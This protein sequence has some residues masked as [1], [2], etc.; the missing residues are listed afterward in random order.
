MVF[1]LILSVLV[2]LLH[3]Y[4]WKR[5][6]RDTT[7]PGLGRR[8]LTGML[9]L[10]A[11]L[12]VATLVLPRTIGPVASS[13]FA[14]PGF[15]WF[16]VLVYLFLTLAV[17]ELPRLALRGW[18]R[19]APADVPVAKAEVPVAP[20]QSGVSRRVFLA[21]ASA[22]VA[23]VTSVATVGAGM[24]NALGPPDLLRVPIRLRKLDPAFNGFRIA[25]VSDVHLGPLTGRAH[26]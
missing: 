10:L 14:W 17:L 23:G 13:W 16:A 25:V 5:L 20:A 19:R 2:A 9:V 4:V 7:R 22:T 21:R 12:V 3:L 24:A 26:T 6:V 1:G 15:V 8:V 11:L 18:V